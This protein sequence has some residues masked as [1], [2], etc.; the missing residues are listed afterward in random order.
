[1]SQETRP[2]TKVLEP[3]DTVMVSSEDGQGR[4]RGRP[5]T[6]LKLRGRSAL[7][8]IDVG[9]EWGAALSDGDPAMVTLSDNRENDWAALSARVTI[10]RDAA[11]ID[12]LWNPFADAFFAKGRETPGLA[13]LETMFEDGQFWSSP[14]GGRVGALV[15]VVRAA[16]GDADDSG[17]EGIVEV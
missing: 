16:I 7:F 10:L 9:T 15:S 4:W 5:L 11:L 13:V 1:M 6:V 17:D 8:L 14:G 3:R 2:L 12:E